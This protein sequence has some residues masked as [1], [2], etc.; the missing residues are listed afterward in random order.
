MA[1]A[2]ALPLKPVSSQRRRG[3][4]P[5]I[6][7]L[8]AEAA[9]RFA[10]RSMLQGNLYARIV[11]FHGRESG[12]RDNIIKPILD[13][14]SGVVYRDDHLIVKCVPERIDT[15]HTYRLSDVDLPPDVYDELVLLLGQRQ[16]HIFYVEVGQVPSR[17]VVFGPIDGGRS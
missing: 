7:A 16:S 6:Q 15:R 3:T 14:L 2:M 9:A 8:R 5:F 4:Q 1:F 13:A 10:D 11:W 12:D 17:Q